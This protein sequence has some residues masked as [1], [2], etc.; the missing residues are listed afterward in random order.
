MYIITVPQHYKN[1][2][3]KNINSPLWL[4]SYHHCNSIFPN[5]KWPVEP[6]GPLEW[7]L[8]ILWW[9]LGEADKDLSRC[10]CDWATVWRNWR[11]SQ[12]VQWTEMSWWDENIMAVIIYSTVWLTLMDIFRKGKINVCRVIAMKNHIWLCFRQ[13]TAGFL[14]KFLFIQLGANYPYW[15]YEQCI[16]FC[17]KQITIVKIVIIK[18]KLFDC[19]G[20]PIVFGAW[21]ICYGKSVW[22]HCIGEY[23]GWFCNLEFFLFSVQVTSLIHLS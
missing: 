11:G 22:M 6:V 1:K 14:S 13:V 9:W 18:K 4:S 10:C 15:T 19:L 8:Q 2:F 17:R 21:T 12:T 3:L 16:M 23:Q 20:M 7:L 5:S